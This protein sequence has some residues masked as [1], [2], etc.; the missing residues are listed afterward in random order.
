MQTTEIDRIIDN[1]KDAIRVCHEIDSSD[2]NPDRSYPFAAGYARS[3]M[4]SA[5]QSLQQ[6]KQS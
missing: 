1:L 4:Q 6:L 2:I 3:S 5:V